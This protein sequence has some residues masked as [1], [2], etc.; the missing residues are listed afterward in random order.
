MKSTMIAAALALATTG[1][2][3]Q[4]QTTTMANDSVSAVVIE[5]SQA[6]D[7]L[8][9]HPDVMAPSLGVG[10]DVCRYGVSAG[11]GSLIF[12]GISGGSYALDEGCEA[13]ADSA[14]FANLAVTAANLGLRDDAIDSLMHRAVAR[15]YQTRDEMLASR[16]E[17][18][19]ELWR[20]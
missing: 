17:P 7:T 15:M 8:K 12:G 18:W 5:G 11:L 20:P 4:T 16:A 2:A 10:A 3:A 6:S 14:H 19:P 13:R 9:T 1:A